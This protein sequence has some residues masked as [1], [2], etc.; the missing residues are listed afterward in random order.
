MI[1]FVLRNLVE[2]AT[3]PGS[4]PKLR[5][6]ILDQA[7][8]G[9]LTADW[10]R[11]HPEVEPASVLL[12]RIRREKRELVKAGKIKKQKELPPVEEGEVSFAVPESWEWVRLGEIVRTGPQNGLSPRRSDNPN[13]PR[14][15]T[16]SATTKGTFDATQYKNIAVSPADAAPF[17]LRPN[18]LL[19]Q[20]GNT[21]EYVGM[22]AIY[23]GPDESF[24]FPD[25]IIRVGILASAD[26]RY[27]HR[28]AVSRHGRGYFSSKA[29]G[30][31][32]TMPKI[33]QQVLTSFSL[34]LPPSDEQTEIVRRVDELMAL[35]DQL[36]AAQSRRD[37]TRRRALVAG[38]SQLTDD[39][40]DQPFADIW[41][42]FTARLPELIQHPDDIKPVQDAILQLAVRGHLTADWRATH[43]DTEPAAT[44]IARIK[45]E[46]QAMVKAGKIKKQKELPPVEADEVPFEVPEGWEWVRLGDAVQMQNGFAFKPTDWADQGLPI[47]R[48]QNLNNKD[49]PFNH[50]AK[51]LDDKYR[52]RAGTFLISWSGTP[53]TS[54]GAHI[55]HGPEAWLNQHIFS[56]ET[57]SLLL[58]EYLR[59]AINT[60]LDELIG[61]AH[62]GVGLQHVTKGVLEQ[63][64]VPAC[65]MDEQ[66]EI[67][68]RVDELMA[69][70]TALAK[71]TATTTERANWLLE[72]VLRTA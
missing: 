1:D 8:R 40:T 57:S 3:L 71:S 24:L 63:L 43:P 29:S 70:C 53:G 41:P 45:E 34:P 69:N 62:G 28:V 18:D 67:V 58:D 65:P 36:E 6:F 5:S 33:N 39:T 13:D 27:V 9:N 23:D 19:F 52:V 10:R 49:A 22:A 7:V 25:L 17:W 46:K 42:R 51:D 21:R 59:R 20:R 72:R 64:L 66:T 54:F 16:L 4:V 47:I 26:V 11:E 56:C 31:S 55:W 38:A 60:R 2:L 68:R 12:E 50:T 14:A 30:T 61:R 32:E 44:L 48:I 37:D 35:C 15:I